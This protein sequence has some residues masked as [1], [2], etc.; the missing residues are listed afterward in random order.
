MPDVSAPA[1]GLLRVG[2]GSAMMLAV[3]TL[4]LPSGRS[5]AWSGVA[6]FVAALDPSAFGPVQIMTLVCLGL[7]TLGFVPRLSLV[8]ATL[9][10]LTLDG[11]LLTRRPIPDLALP[12][13]VMAA[14]V[15]APWQQGFG[16]SWALDRWRGHPSHAG[17]TSPGLALW[18]PAIGLAAGYLV[19]ALAAL[20]A[21]VVNRLGGGAARHDVIEGALQAPVGLLVLGVALLLVGWFRHWGAR[22]ALGLV[23]SG[24]LFRLFLIRGLLWPSWWVLLLGFLPWQ[25]MTGALVRRLPRVTVLADGECPMCRRAA[26]ALHTLDWF[27]RLEFADASDDDERA[28]VAPGLD[29]DRALAEMYVVDAN[30]RMA[31]GYD[32]YLSL[33]SSLPVLWIPRLIGMIPPIAS[34]GHLVYRHIA[35]T[36]TRVGRCTDDVCDV[37]AAPLPRRV[38]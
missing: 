18:I 8:M 15:V 33:A 17:A 13:M 14:M 35:A 7:F 19:V 24:L 22:L 21:A 27:D 2:Y 16:L 38:V 4:A 3:W 36:R 10:M 12:T 1:L 9:F 30:G 23:A 31:A 28:R 5:T 25:Q 34:L 37:G 6:S 29:R 32:G 11:L 20:S 26:R